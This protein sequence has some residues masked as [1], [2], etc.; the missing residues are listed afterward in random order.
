MAGLTVYDLVR[1][2]V[3]LLEVREVD[4]LVPDDVGRSPATFGNGG[5]GR[6]HGGHIYRCLMRG[7][8]RDGQDPVLVE[9]H[10]SPEDKG[11][12]QCVEDR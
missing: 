10:G 5:R 4:C 1:A 7:L 6:R 11:N 8:I 3:E 2:E 9:L 12:G